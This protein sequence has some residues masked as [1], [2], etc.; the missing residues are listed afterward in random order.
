M[1]SRARTRLLRRR[2]T[3]EATTHNEN[4]SVTSVAIS[5]TFE[6]I[7]PSLLLGLSRMRLFQRGSP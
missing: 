3:G 7:T 6:A 2:M 1:S 5:P 4:C